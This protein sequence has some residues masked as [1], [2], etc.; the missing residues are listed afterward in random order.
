[1]DDN[2]YLEACRLRAEADRTG[3]AATYTSAAELFELCGMPAAAER[4]RQRAEAVA[5]WQ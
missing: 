3:N 5:S 4:C 1:M 2:T